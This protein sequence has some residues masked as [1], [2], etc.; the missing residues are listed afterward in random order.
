MLRDSCSINTTFKFNHKFFHSDEQQD[1]NSCI[2]TDCFVSSN[3]DVS[4]PLPCD[5]SIYCADA[6]YTNWPF[7][8]TSCSFSFMSR[9]KSVEKLIL[10]GQELSIDM[11]GAEKNRAW[12]L[13]SF[14]KIN[15]NQTNELMKFS[16]NPKAS[17][18]NVILTF[19]IVRHSKE[20]FLQVVI[21]QTLLLFLNVFTLILEV[22]QNCRWILYVTY[23]FSHDI[24]FEQLHWMLPANSD[25]IPNVF[26]F[27]CT[28][29]YITVW[30]LITSILMKTFM[31]SDDMSQLIIT[32][33]DKTTNS[34]VGRF[35][36]KTEGT[37]A[38]DKTALRKN[39][40][41]FIDRILVVLVIV[42]YG[43]SFITLNP[44]NGSDD[45][46]HEL[47]YESVY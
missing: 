5:F 26:K 14:S 15:I 36:V 7:D 43:Y 9:T 37:D 6:E 13:T 8:H 34:T 45:V 18:S 16:S 31:E 33:I 39:F 47:L 44:K 11:D 2:S 42:I 30:L 3:G 38:A 17:F 27:L 10:T 24:Y 35:I 40:C 25:S 23:I 46:P 29:Y 20:M 28:S 41:C 19:V 1:L 4:C 22:D 12:E 32:I 21:P